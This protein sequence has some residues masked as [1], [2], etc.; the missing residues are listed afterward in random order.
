MKLHI[1]RIMRFV[2]ILK[3]LQMIVVMESYL[4]G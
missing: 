3:A 4:K 1:I 2:N